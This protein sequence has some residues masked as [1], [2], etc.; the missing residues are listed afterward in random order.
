MTRSQKTPTLESAPSGKAVL[1]G[2]PAPKAAAPGIAH[3]VLRAENTATPKVS[4]FNKVRDYTAAA[5]VRATGLYPYFRTISSAQD[6]EVIIAGQK[7]LM[8]GSNS[9]LGLTNDPRIK[10]AARAAVAK[11][12]SGCAGSRFLNGSLDIHLELE[13]ALAKLVK[14]EA[15]LLYSTGFQVN[16]GVM[17][18]TYSFPYVLLLIEEYCL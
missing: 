16:L 10:E 12:G 17:S 14:K 8:L 15:V 3:S 2:A 13:Q 18:A 11:Y 9:Y 6:T 1:V 4:L 5:E 7:V